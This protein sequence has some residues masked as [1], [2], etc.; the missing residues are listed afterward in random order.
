MKNRISARAI[1]QCRVMDARMICF[2]YVK[3]RLSRIWSNHSEL[4]A[5]PSSQRRG[6]CGISQKSRSH[7]RAADGV[8]RPAKRFGRTDHPGAPASMKLPRHPSS[9]R[10][11]MQAESSS[12]PSWPFAQ[13]NRGCAARRPLPRLCCSCRARRNGIRGR[14]LGR[15]G[16]RNR[17][18]SA[19]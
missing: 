18:V 15:H 9:A 5:F 7:R 6:G 11:G 8:V 2:W 3:W 10:R 4:K 13:S 1:L 14:R 17:G 16:C 19:G 12:P